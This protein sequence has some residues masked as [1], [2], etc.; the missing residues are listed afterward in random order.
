MS[1]VA[2]RKGQCESEGEGD[3][4]RKRRKTDAPIE[5]KNCGKIKRY[6]ARA[7]AQLEVCKSATNAIS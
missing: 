3:P 1:A 2:K 7:C 5:I 4:T 6:V